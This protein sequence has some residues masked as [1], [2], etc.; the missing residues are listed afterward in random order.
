MSWEQE[1]EEERKQARRVYV[2]FEFGRLLENGYFAVEN[3]FLTRGRK[4]WR[5]AFAL[6]YLFSLFLESVFRILSVALFLTLVLFVT[7]RILRIIF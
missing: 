3:R 1:M 5:R 6:Y 4:I 7:D 2:T